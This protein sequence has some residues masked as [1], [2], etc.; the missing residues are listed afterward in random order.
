MPKCTRNP[1]VALRRAVALMAV[2][3]RIVVEEAR[4]DLAE[5]TRI[6]AIE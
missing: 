2:D 5:V 3:F 4:V 1:E 6:S